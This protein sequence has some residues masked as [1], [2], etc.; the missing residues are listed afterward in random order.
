M[1]TVCNPLENIRL[2]EDIIPFTEFRRT[3]S[4]CFARTSGTHRPLIITQNGRAA[5]ILLDISDFD[6]LKETLSIVEDVHVAEE[7]IERGETI[8]AEDLRTKLH[9]EREASVGFE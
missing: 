3:L 8:S 7:E 5:K 4:S 2:S 6:E 1:K 9:S